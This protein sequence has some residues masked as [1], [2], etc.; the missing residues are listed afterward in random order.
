MPR[1]TAL[2]GPA[3]GGQHDHDIFIIS[4]EV[5]PA[6]LNTSDGPLNPGQILFSHQHVTY[7]LEGYDLL[8][9]IEAHPFGD[10]VDNA[11]AIK[12]HL[13]GGFE[14]ALPSLKLLV[15]LKFIKGH[16]GLPDSTIIDTS[17]K[18]SMP[19]AVDRALSQIDPSWLSHLLNLARH[20]TL[21]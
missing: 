15:Y 7:G 13:Q 19:D 2:I 8:I 18:M 4:S 21:E 3:L 14:A 11:E 6:G 20:A 17:I 5:V 10:R 1:V 16:W 9:E 12:K